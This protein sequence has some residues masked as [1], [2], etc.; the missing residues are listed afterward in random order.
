MIIGGKL[1]EWEECY[2]K[3]QAGEATA[4]ERL[5]SEYEP[6]ERKQEAHWRKLLAETLTEL[7]GF[8][9]VP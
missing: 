3:Q 7:V 8:P 2:N 6:S 4:L 5:I 9:V 1:P